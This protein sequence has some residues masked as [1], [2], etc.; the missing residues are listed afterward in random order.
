MTPKSKQLRMRGKTHIARELKRYIELRDG[1]GAVLCGLQ[2]VGSNSELL[3]SRQL[4]IDAGPSEFQ[5]D[6]GAVSIRSLRKPHA[7][8]A[9]AVQKGSFTELEQRSFQ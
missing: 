5:S 1:V 3:T 4:I 6:A 9:V 2:S 8:S 7:P